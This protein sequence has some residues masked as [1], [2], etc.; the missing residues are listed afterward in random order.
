[1]AQE[2][3]QWLNT[4]YLHATALQHIAH[5]YQQNKALPSVQLHA[6][7][8]VNKFHMLQHD[9]IRAQKILCSVPDMFVYHKVKPCGVMLSFERALRSQAFAQLLS[10]ITGRKVACANIE[11]QSFKHRHYTILHDKLKQ[12]RGIYLLFDL[13]SL[14]G[15][16]WGGY[17]YIVNEGEELARLAPQAN[18]VTL[19]TLA[20]KVQHFTKYVNYRAGK[21]RRVVLV[22]RF[23]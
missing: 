9:A 23:K 6:F 4:D 22:A 21:N 8:N 13:T 10:F 1:M 17:T 20:G 7:L 5:A 3:K 12:E 16:A 19:F 15:A 11:W 2:L 18:A 14:W